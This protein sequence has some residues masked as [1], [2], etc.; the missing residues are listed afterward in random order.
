MASLWV[1]HFNSTWENL[2]ILMSFCEEGLSAIT[3]R[4]APNGS[5]QLRGNLDLRKSF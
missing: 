3:R 2:R 4:Y 5:L 1:V